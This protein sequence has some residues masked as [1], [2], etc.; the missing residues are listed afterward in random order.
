MTL[1]ASTRTSP[2]VMTDGLADYIPNGIRQ[3]IIAD[4]LFEQLDYLFQ[5]ADQERDR[6]ERVKAILVEPF[7]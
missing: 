4:V 6:L 7:N 5:F 3:D 1:K 2:E